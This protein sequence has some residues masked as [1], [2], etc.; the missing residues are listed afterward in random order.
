VGLGICLLALITSTLAQTTTVYSISA[1]SGCGGGSWSGSASSGQAVCSEV[2]GFAQSVQPSCSVPGTFSSAIYTGNT[3]GG[4]CALS[5]TNQNGQNCGGTLPVTAATTPIS[6]KDA[7][8]PPNPDAVAG[9]PIVMS[10]GNKIQSAVDYQA[11]GPNALQFTRYYNSATIASSAANF[12]QGWMHNYAAS[13][14]TISSTAV[15]V[16]RPDGKAITFNLV[17]STWTPDADVSDRLVELLNGSTVTGWQYT[18]AANDSLETYDAYGNLSSI[19][20]REGTVVSMTYATGTGAPTFPGQLLSVTDSFGRKISF[21]YVNDFIHTMTDANGGIYTYAYGALGTGVLSSVTYPDTFSESY[22]YNESAYTGG[23]NLPTA[24]TGVMDEN[25]SRYTTTWYGTGGAAIQTQ[26]A[27]ALAGNVGLFK[28]TNTLDGTGRIQSVALVDP[29]GAARGRTFASIVGRNRVSTVTKPAANGSPT[30][31]KSYNY[32]A[33]GNVAEVIDLNGNVQCAV[34][35]LTRNL[36]TGRVEGMVPGSTCPTNIA[37]YVPTAGT[38]QRKILTNW[39]AIWHL[40]IKR[41]EPLKITTWVYNGDGGVYCAP[42]TAKVGVNPIGVVCSRSEQAT[43]DATGGAGFGATASGSP[44]V[45]AYT[46]NS[47][48]QVLTAKG[49]RTDVNST[50]TYTYYTCT[51]GAQCGQ[52]DTISNAL[53]QVTTFLTYNGNGQ[54]LTISDPNGVVTTLTYDARLRLKSK[55]VGTETTSYSYYPT[56]LLDVVTLPDSSTIQFTYDAAHR[57]TQ[58][59]DGLGNYVKYTLDAM[60]NRTAEN[61]YDPSGTLHRSH[62]RVFNAVNELYQDIGAANTA[63]VTT[64]L[65][66]DANG[67]VLTSDAPLARNTTK[68]YDA[69]NRLSQITDPNSGITKLAYDGRGNL[70]SVIDPRTFTTTY[71]NDGFGDVTQLVSPDTGTSK[72]TYDSGGNLQTTT[73][74]RSALGTYSYDAL[75]RVTKI[76][77]SDQT[78]QFTYDTGTNGKGRLTGASDANHSM[79]WGYDTHGRVTSKSQTVAGVTKSVGYTFTNAD[80]TTLLTPYGQSVTYGYTNHRITSIAVNGTTVLSGATY[81]PFGSA[82]GWT[83]GNAATAS[84]T[85]DEDGNPKQIVSAGVTNAYTIDSA[86]RVTGITD[87]GLSSDSWTFGYDVLDRVKTGTSSAMTR[88]YIRREQ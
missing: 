26:L 6:P 57:L 23:L 38:V 24:L 41:A 15:A 84:H 78:I 71:T 33:N 45:W 56:G 69:L 70:A 79:T 44:R 82:T 87:S 48:G 43:T 31:S 5:C 42:T 88:G 39:H 85:Y 14:N 3:S 17:G 63:A 27:P 46:Y 37:T 49:P 60:G 72:K 47:F 55:Q 12:G 64:T 34:Y 73:D 66:Y 68:T 35:D 11:P 75:N 51:T 76:V 61:S 67:N 10:I 54:P 20:Y 86:F 22:L 77:Y 53:S 9:D 7:G 21:S 16:S 59:T 36:E 19:A 65:G 13:I 74:A 28:M 8:S 32:D 1:T 2:E 52:I 30:A 25:N 4:L 80:L 50:T 58:I 62:T 18:N 40:P 83:W 29:L 81:D